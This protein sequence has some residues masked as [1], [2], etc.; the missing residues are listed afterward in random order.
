VPRSCGI[1]P[2]L[3]YGIR[4]TRRRDRGIRSTPRASRY[5]IRPTRR[6]GRSIRTTP[7][8]SRYGIPDAN[9]SGYGIRPTPTASRYGIRP[10][11]RLNERCARE[12]RHRPTFP[13]TMRHLRRPATAEGPRHPTDA[14]DRRAT[15]SDRPRRLAEGEPGRGI[16]RSCAAGSLKSSAVATLKHAPG[17]GPTPTQPPRSSWKLRSPILGRGTASDRRGTIGCRRAHAPSRPRMTERS[18]PGRHV[19]AMARGNAP[20][21]AKETHGSAAFRARSTEHTGPRAQLPA[22]RLLH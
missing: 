6:R 2:T 15:A 1:R 18:V 13:G 7:T 14:E 19:V 8:A 20:Q 11:R 5:G 10:T 17:S 4:P 3:H 16:R 21:A 9:A 12:A 22:A